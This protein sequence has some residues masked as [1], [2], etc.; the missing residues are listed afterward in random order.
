M[1]KKIGGKHN[2]VWKR[3]RFKGLKRKGISETFWLN[4]GPFSTPIPKAKNVQHCVQCTIDFFALEDPRA[5]STIQ[6]RPYCLLA[7]LLAIWLLFFFFLNYVR[8][9]IFGTTLCNNSPHGKL[10]LVRI[11]P[12][13]PL[14]YSYQSQLVMWH[15][16][17]PKIMPLT[18]I[19]IYIYIFF[20]WEQNLYRL[21]G[22]FLK[23]WD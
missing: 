17:A 19:Y 16:I 23:G 13:D 1:I 20:F 8:D 4:W 12:H 6:R 7:F 15:K 10:W 5:V 9:I 11:F 3:K 2:I 18:Y 14:T 21:I 22:T